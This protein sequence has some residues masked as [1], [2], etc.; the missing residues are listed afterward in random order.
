[1]GNPRRPDAVSEQRELRRQTRLYRRH[2]PV[3]GRGRGIRAWLQVPAR[4]LVAGTPRRP[5]NGSPGSCLSATHGR[6]RNSIGSCFDLSKLIHKPGDKAVG[7]AV[8]GEGDR[9]LQCHLAGLRAPLRIHA[10]SLSA[11]SGQEQGQGR[12][13]VPLH[14][15]GLL[16]RPQLPHLDDLNHQLHRWL[17]E[18]ANARVHATTRRIVADH[19]PRSAPASSRCP[20]DPSR[21]CCGWSG[22]SPATAWSPSAT[23]STA[24]SIAP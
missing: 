1:M 7:T 14:P 4:I 20:P 3:N 13:P 6:A 24:C 18:D 21:Q 12:A 16:P 11:L 17:D 23:T 5:L 8:T 19:S 22:A 2:Y 9:H 10:K 15:P